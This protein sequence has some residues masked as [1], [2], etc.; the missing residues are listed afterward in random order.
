[1]ADPLSIN[2]NVFADIKLIVCRLIVPATSVAAY[3]VAA[4]WKNFAP[5]TCSNP[6]YNTTTISACDSYTWANNNQTY[7]TSGVYSG[8][9]ANCVTEKLE[10]TITPRPVAPTGLACLEKAVWNPE[11]CDY[12]IFIEFP[13]AP[14]VNCYQST[15]WDEETCS[16]II[17]G[18]QP[19]QPA[20]ACYET[21]NWNASSCQYDIVTTIPALP[22]I[23]CYETA[24]WNYET[25]QY[26]ITG[27]QAEKPAVAS[28]ESTT[29][30]A[31]MCEW[32]ISG[33][34]PTAPDVNC[35][36]TATWNESTRTYD[37]T[38]VLPEAPEVNCYETATWNPIT[39]E[40]DIQGELP[41]E[42]SVSCYQTTTW[43][44]STCTWDMTD[45][46][47][48]APKVACY[49]RAIW[50]TDTCDYDITGEKPS[51]PVVACYE[52]A[53]WNEA[54]CDYV[55]SGT[56]P[57]QPSLA[58][59]EKA[60]WNSELCDY[61][62]TGTKPAA[63][64][65]L[66]YQIATFDTTSCK[67]VVTGSQPKITLISGAG[68]I[69]NG[70]SKTLTL[71][72]GTVGTI[73]WQSSTTSA[74]ASDF[75]DISDT[76]DLASL[77]VTPS[78][79][80]WY[81]ALAS[82]GT[83]PPATSAAVAVIVNQ[84]TAVGTLSALSSSL[85]TGTG[86]TLTVSAA[87]GGTIAWQKATVINGV[88]GAFTTVSGNATA[89]LATGNLTA[90]AAYR[91]VV[92]SGVCPSSISEPITIR[93]SP[94]AV[95]RTISGGG[96]ICNGLS[97]ILTLATGSV[98]TTQWQSSTTSATASDF[99]DINDAIN[100]A[101]LT[102]TP[103]LTTWFRVVA[104]SGTCSQATSAAVAVTVSQPTAVGTLSAL[105][106]SLCTGSETT[107][108]LSSATGNITWQSALV[109][110]G[111]I[112]AF[113]TLTG[114][115]ST[116]LVI[117]N[118]TRTTAYRVVVSSGVCAPSISEPMTITVNRLAV[119]KSLR[120]AGA[121]CYGESKTLTL[122]VGSVGTTQ[123]QSSTTS[124]TAS[125]FTDI[126]DAINL[127]SLPVTPA[128]TTWYRIVATSGACATATSGAV[129]VTV[130]EQAAVGT[131]SSLSSSLCVGSGTTLTLSSATGNIVWQSATVTNGVIS[132]FRALAANTSKT[133]VTGN[134]SRTTAY[135]VVVSSGVCATSISEPITIS[136]NPAA[137]LTTIT[138]STTIATAV[139]IG[140]PK[141]LTLAAGY[142]GTIEWLIANSSTGTY[143]VIPD[144][145]A[146]TYNYVPTSAAVKYFKV[147]LTSSPCSTTQTTTT[148]V[149]V[150]A[151]ACTTSSKIATPIEVASTT[152]TV[153]NPNLYSENISVSL[154]PSKQT[155]IEVSAATTSK[156]EEEAID[157]SLK[158]NVVAYPNPYSANFNLS[159]TSLNT[160]TLAVAV[161][162]LTGRQIEN[163]LVN[164]SDINSI[165]LGD[166]YPSGVYNVVVTQGA[167]IK[168]LRVIKK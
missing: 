144:A 11:I 135:R 41:L 44:S 66:C 71:A 114:N 7:T 147:R 112:S 162:D 81:R 121:I 163:R 99:T 17:S 159:L 48:T 74:L 37:V 108:T 36:E 1:V 86:T 35:Y 139:C 20:L 25:C 82:N 152:S 63:P 128:V 88:T 19:E 116:T 115:T 157:T 58:C 133:L 80:T 92:S 91:V 130:S 64:T 14:T 8:L 107:L 90:S 120:G 126:N 140:S 167:A 125:D 146:A 6:T 134:L 56:K 24:V 84:P 43:N 127:A 149:A 51:E 12:E 77:T 136:V 47:P 16:W 4:V 39:C 73:Q 65:L 33:V 113:R 101:S 59:Y 102:V 151:K 67:W 45:E 55:I 10:L 154:S 70:L 138:G 78:V 3:Q 148:G 153:V 141:T 85:C 21:A 124:A 62:I 52:T 131:I 31:S 15:E 156:I 75:T 110:N 2:A 109:T 76:R 69:C 83:C 161:Y 118:L 57:V 106:T 13:I 96:T 50:N 137:K 49:E 155:V 145:T 168:T 143:T 22:T 23:A 142:V 164:S 34:L 68:A 5:I 42:P 79:S 94:S 97:K 26:D 103:A 119:A 117:G 93:V 29:W 46:K 100:Q 38:G 53:T 87:T 61:D 104:T 98:G 95:A 166:K 105:N 30:N 18:T 28:Y 111:V 123:W 129:A 27:T 132:A 160:A 89:T 9:T 60:I 158:F 150:Y 40:Y 165:A 54:T 122:G 72:T 32:N